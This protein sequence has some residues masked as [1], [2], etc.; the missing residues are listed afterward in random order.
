[1]PPPE[2]SI[3]T[4]Q[5]APSITVTREA[6]P[7]AP[8]HV[9]PAPAAAPAA[10]PAPPA[11]PARV[12]PQVNFNKDCERPDYPAAAAR[13]EATGTTRVKVTVGT[14]GRAT[15]VEV[16][17]P[18]GPTREHKLLDRA[19]AAAIKDTCKFKPGSVDGKPQP[20]TTFVEYAWRLE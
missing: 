17:G 12:A 1:M 4:P 14:D 5:A 16:V 8:V 11:P 2:I 3:A 6:P 10:P 15:D 18:S 13:A 19:A 7:P 9:A 20:L